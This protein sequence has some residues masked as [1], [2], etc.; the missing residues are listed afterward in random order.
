MENSKITALINSV[1]TQLKHQK[2]IAK[3]KGETFN[4]FSILGIE[5]KENKTHSNFI[6]EL[7]SPEGS[8]F[9]G[10]IFLVEFLKQI[11]HTFEFDVSTA[12][13]FKEFPIG[14]VTT[15]SGGRIDILIKDGNDNTISIENKIYAGDQEN[16][17][18]RYSNYNRGKNTVYYLT[19]NGNEAS[20]Y[21]V[22]VDNNIDYNCLSYR[23][24][25]IDWL[26]KCKELVI[27]VAQTREA[28]KQY[29]LLIKKLTN[30][31]ADQKMEKELKKIL[32]ANYDA[33]DV[34]SSYKETIDREKYIG[35]IKDLVIRLTNDL[36]ADWIVNESADLFKNWSGFTIQHKDW[37][38]YTEV[39]IQS[40]RKPVGNRNNCCVGAF[41]EAFDKENILKEIN[42][43]VIG[44]DWKN[45]N[46]WLG[47]KELFNFGNIE[48]RKKAFLN[49]EEYLGN[50]LKEL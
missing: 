17:L 7:L 40:E 44:S 34:I 12:Y 28:I 19:L 25:I 14:P 37:P 20:T 42:N 35:I 21:S 11:N 4:I 18:L 10:N 13:V 15:E 1:S 26:Q 32:V 45:N 33:F 3:I 22:G 6:A 23:D 43:G 47:Q 9:F 49:Y 48:E 27:D 50:I 16:Q 36:G 39:S 24:D 8:H 46:N 5:T 30:Q 41:H 38:K 31:L 2:E 29:Q